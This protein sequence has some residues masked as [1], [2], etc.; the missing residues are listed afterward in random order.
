MLLN[1]KIT[2]APRIHFVE[3]FPVEAIP[4]HLYDRVT[5]QELSEEEFRSM[6]EMAQEYRK[7]PIIRA[8]GKSQAVD[9]VQDFLEF[10]LKDDKDAL[11][12]D[13]ALGCPQFNGN[14]V[15]C[16]TVRKDGVVVKY[17]RVKF[18]RL[19]TDK[20]VGKQTC[21]YDIAADRPVAG[22]PISIIGEEN[23]TDNFNAIQVRM[24]A[25]NA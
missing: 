24:Y 13:P 19:V 17:L 11:M 1:A 23:E 22:S 6:V 14:D 7:A 16:V 3:S 10:V 9:S 4:S 20:R 21:L 5:I 25:M 8:N 12:V 15:F 18:K 2:P